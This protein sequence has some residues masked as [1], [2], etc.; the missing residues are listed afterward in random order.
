MQQ[1]FFLLDSLNPGHAAIFAVAFL[2]MFV[3]SW[4]ALKGEDSK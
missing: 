1:P 3:I 2:V 4:H